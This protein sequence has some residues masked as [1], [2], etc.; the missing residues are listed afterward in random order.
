MSTLPLLSV[1]PT[2]D[3]LWCVNEQGGERTAL[4]YFPSKYGALKHA[5]KAARSKTTRARDAILD[6]D[7]ATSASRD[8]E[9]PASPPEVP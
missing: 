9:G 6:P 1:T 3:G 5:V 4:A 7:G 2:K 8:Y